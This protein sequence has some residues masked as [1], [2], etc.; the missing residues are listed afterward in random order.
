MSRQYP[1]IS[2][3]IKKP[4]NKTVKCKCGQ[5]AKFQTVIQV[6]YFR[7]D[8]DFIWSCDEHRRDLDFLRSQ[9]NG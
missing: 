4:K 2:G 3:V 6:N 8:D 9:L 1:K 5:V 7:G